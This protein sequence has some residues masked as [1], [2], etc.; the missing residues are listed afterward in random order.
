MT[1]L[2]DLLDKGFIR[3]SVSPW[4]APVLFVKK[5]DGSMRMCI[6]YRELN[7]L[8]IKNKYPLP[9]IDNLFD[10]LQGASW[11]SKIDLRSGY[12]QLKVRE[13]DIPKTAFRKRYGHYEFLV[14]SFGLT[15]APAA[16]MDLIN[17]V[18]RPMLDRSVIVFIDGI[19][20]YSKSEGDHACHIRKVLE[21]LRREKLYAK[22]SK[23]A[24][25]LREVQFLGH[26]ISPEGIMV[27]PAKVEAVMKWNPPKTPTE[28]RSFL[29]LAGYYRKFI[30]DF[31]RIA[32]PLTKLTRKE[33]KYDWG[34]T[35]VQ[36]FEELKRR[37]TEAPILT[38][39]DGNE[40][41]YYSE[42]EGVRKGRK[43][44][45]CA[46]LSSEVLYR[47]ELPTSV[48]RHKF[49]WK[50]KPVDCVS[51]VQLKKSYACMSCQLRLVNSLRKETRRAHGIR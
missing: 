24:F 30:Q 34:P 3:P 29:G 39:P 32:T 40:D 4:G 49:L 31:S 17:W 13:Q 36:A 5:K 26:V 51:P 44:A 1:Q 6:D 33:V 16:F 10:Q 22:L 45:D 8:T 35:Q 37:L 27:D 50:H 21:M 2:Q 41:I 19:L 18:C 28:V 23:C 15:N 7:K 12:H 25:W 47:Y 48:R 11:F 46:L 38:L 9:R 20:I 14:M 43:L 42:R